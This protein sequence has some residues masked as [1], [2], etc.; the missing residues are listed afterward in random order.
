MR[1]TLFAFIVLLATQTFGV[2]LRFVH[3]F[4]GSGGQSKPWHTTVFKNM[5]V[6]TAMTGN[7]GE[8]RLCAYINNYWKWQPYVTPGQ[9]FKCDVLGDYYDRTAIAN[10]KLFFAATDGPA[11][12]VQLYS[13]SGIDG[14]KPKMVYTPMTNSGSPNIDGM[15]GMGKKVYFSA[16]TPTTGQ[17]LFVYDDS[18]GT[19]QLLADMDP[20]PNSTYPRDYFIFNNKL[21]F[22]TYDSK[23]RC[24]DPATGLFT[25]AASFD[26]GVPVSFVTVGNKVYFAA[27][28]VA[29]G[30]ELYVMDTAHNVTRLTDIRAGYAN[31]I[32]ADF[33]HNP[34]IGLLNNV[35]YFMVY[36]GS[37]SQQLWK[38]DI[39]SS[40][41]S[42]VMQIN[43]APTGGI[44]PKPSRFITYN[45]NL[46]FSADDGV[47]GIELWKY[48]GVNQPAM[49]YDLDTYI[50]FSG[51]KY[52]SSDPSFF[53]IYKD[54]LYFSANTTVSIEL[55]SL[56][57][58]MVQ[59]DEP[60]SDT[61]LCPNMTFKLYYHTS[62][63]FKNGN[64]FNV[65]LSDAIGSFIAPAN[66]GTIT[67][68]TSS[69]ILCAIPPGT[70]PGNYRIRITSTNPATTSRTNIVPI[71]I[72]YPATA[73]V[74]VSASPD[75]II[76]GGTNV[77]LTATPT[78]GGI[79]P[80]YAWMINGSLM[81]GWTGPLYYSN[82]FADGDNVCVTMNTSLLCAKPSTV[83]SCLT[84]HYTDI[85]DVHP[86]N[87]LNIY[88]NPNKGE[89]VLKGKWNN[90]VQLDITVTDLAGRI[91]HS[92]K[93]SSAMGIINEAVSIANLSKG[94]YLF[95]ARDGMETKV[96]KL[97][98]E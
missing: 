83:S 71:N 85:N 93:I 88:P 26:A 61:V 37:S 47:H 68:T 56:A 82:S 16:H 89:F 62:D 92:E 96:I 35:L 17:E 7:G 29:Y 65:E 32:Y 84:M 66:I 69:F 51:G 98:V 30:M 42:M 39:A 90:N 8:D 14:D 6:T 12:N 48:D 33:E 95:Y 81:P 91:V 43:T 53:T 22:A 77:T 64:I 10:N 31:S 72:P 27:Q 15:I 5:L 46:Y 18:T 79:S 63:T 34:S 11:Y 97:V 21:Y 3:K 25:V 36:N 9:E 87:L 59:I 44:I 94:V 60:F 70:A 50:N 28:T 23:V 75:S 4:N 74:T 13:W 40:T 67:K 54:V 2:P 1:S 80:A 24:Y 86:M 78:N 19:G 45:N 57:D 52:G 73:S 76:T 20:G 49:V 55:Y 38:Y 41:P 58:T